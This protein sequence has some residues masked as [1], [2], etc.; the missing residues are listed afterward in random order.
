MHGA[1]NCR[2]KRLHTDGVGAECLSTPKLRGAP[3]PHAMGGTTTRTTAA[4]GP[5]KPAGAGHNV[6]SSDPNVARPP[7][8]LGSADTTWAP[9][10]VGETM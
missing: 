10:F 6:P 4:A 1:G 7:E 5:P 3:P 9:L 2:A 8:N